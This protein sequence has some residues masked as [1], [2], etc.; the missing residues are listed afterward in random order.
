MLS[1]IIFIP[2]FFLFLELPLSSDS[3][4]MQKQK[5]AM[6]ERHMLKKQASYHW[7]PWVQLNT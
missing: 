3:L 6:I 5:N 7:A 2:C 1:D 4:V